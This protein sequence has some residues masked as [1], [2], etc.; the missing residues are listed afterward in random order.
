MRGVGVFVSWKERGL[1]MPRAIPAA[2]RRAIWH[3][4]QLG[5][6]AVEI[7]HEL[8]LAVRTVRHLLRRFRSQ[9]ERAS[10]AVYH[11]CGQHQAAKHDDLRQEVRTLRQH[12]PRWGADGCAWSCVAGIPIATCLANVPCSVGFTS[13]GCPLPWRELRGVSA[14]SV[15]RVRIRCGTSTPAS[16][17]ASPRER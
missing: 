13:S 16:R 11:A 6:S 4:S 17:N 1:I 12:H 3:R 10:Q 9:G 7:A 8:Q 5:Q 2:L 15:P 14:T